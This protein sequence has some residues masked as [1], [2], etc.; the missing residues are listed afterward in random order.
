MPGARLY[1]IAAPP[2]C[3]PEIPRRPTGVQPGDPKVPDPPEQSLG[4]AG[5][6]AGRNCQPR[7]GMLALTG[8]SASGFNL[9]RAFQA[10]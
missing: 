6:R 1:L 7:I 9:E 10:I 3:Y 2:G 4:E 5:E 8:E